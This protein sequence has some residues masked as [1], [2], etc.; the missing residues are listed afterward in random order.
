MAVWQNIKRLFINPDVQTEPKQQRSLST[1]S[2]IFSSFFAPKAASGAVVSDATVLGI[3]AVWRAV[4]VIAETI[5][6]LPFN[7]FIEDSVGN[8]K[9]YTKGKINNLVSLEPSM[10]YTSFTF[11]ETMIFHLCFRGNF[12]A[13][14]HRDSNGRPIELEILNPDSIVV[15]RSNITRRLY[16]DVK[17]EDSQ[18]ET[19]KD[20]DVLHVV[21]F[22]WDGLK[23]KSP[24]EVHK[25]SLGLAISNTS[26][27]SDLY[28]N[29]AQLSGIL[30]A[31]GIMTDDQVK[32]LKESW[33]TNYEG[34]G[35]RRKTAII[36]NGMDYQAI[37]LSPADAQYIQSAKLS[38][39]DVARIFGVP[40]H[41]LSQLDRATFSNIEQQAIEF[42]QNTIR[43][44]ARRI[45][46]EF[47]RKLIPETDKGKA[48]MRF[49]LNGIL[50]GDTVARSNYY[51]T[52]FNIGAMSPN[53]IRR[54]ENM[55]TVEGGDTYYVPLNMVDG[56]TVTDS[57]TQDDLSQDK[58]AA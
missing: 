41:M 39:E 37:G 57:A 52:M 36:E 7:A 20:T 22:A 23:G 4:H 13:K 5:A 18:Q 54:L 16:Y 34:A 50:R 40:L 10:L 45:E 26:Y 14:I 2:Q 55:N 21:S 47:T 8:I 1:V 17:Y 42:Y 58:L 9:T 32:R 43:P 48:Y 53:E 30:K 38:I 31:P 11:K 51:R 49:N 28:A 35:N 25:E 24:I 12:Y 33:A 3:T 46:E 15:K 6:S 19:L 44:W 29:G 56:D 27:A